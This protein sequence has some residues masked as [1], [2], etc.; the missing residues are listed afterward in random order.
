MRAGEIKRWLRSDP[1]VL[2]WRLLL[3]YAALAVC[4][5][6]FLIYNRAGI[7]PVDSSE[8][9]NLL[10]G[11]LVF[12][13]VSIIYAYAVFIIASLLPFR[14]RAN[15]WYRGAMFWYWITAAAVSTALNL[16]DAVYFRYAQKRFT[17]D[18]IFFADNDNTIRL[19]FKFLGENWYMAAVW[20]VLVAA[21]ALLYGRKIKPETPIRNPWVY[22]GVNLAVLAAAI[23]LCIGGVRGGFSRMTRPI[24]MSNATQYTPSPAKANL[25][26][27]NPFAVLRTAGRA[28]SLPY[29]EY[30]TP[31]EL[32]EIYTPY[33]YPEAKEFDFTP[34]I[35]IFVL[36]SFSAEHS[37]FLNPELYDGEPGYTPFL[38]S[39]MR[40]GYT[41]TNAHSS[42]H[43]SIE[44]LP[45]VM[46]SIPSFQ[47]PFVLMPQ[48][49]GRSR[50]LPQILTDKGYSTLFFNGSERGSMGF[51]AYMRSAGVQTVYSRV[52]FEAARGKKDFDGYWG[53]WDMPFIDW[54]GEVLGTVEQPFF[55]SVFTISSHHPFKVP[56]EY[57]SLPAGQTR[58]HRGIQ[59]TDLS[60]R[61]FFERFG[62]ED[63]FRNSV[64]VFVADHVSS[65]IYAPET[66]T[67]PGRSRI[68]QFIYTP[69][70]LLRGVDD[71]ISQQIDLMPTLMNFV[72]ADEP[73]F[74]FGRDLLGEPER[75][76]IVIEY[77]QGYI[78]QTDSVM[79]FFDG[80]RVTQAFGISDIHME[81]DINTPE[82]KEIGETERLLKAIIQQY[83][84]HIGRMDYT[85]PEVEE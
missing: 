81:H 74:A 75:K 19:I 1:A 27:S 80:E 62:S 33:H 46:G 4:R 44:A 82:N 43:K 23:V 26:L 13:T 24:A 21:L 8:V 2:A 17:A 79:V 31:Q 56:D 47:T 59:Y 42:G 18:E 68:I 60:I 69:Y 77:S 3:I 55:S 73:Y 40:S 11:S 5:L 70:G 49:L 54:M 65:E 53:I 36:E 66:N 12:D 28:G 76:P 29:R 9:W 84:E 6:V 48:A 83:Y 15:R 51:E 71:R 78:A 57:M 61:R 34:N 30:Y 50:Q 37:A 20:A 32:A 72:P 85:V 38:D 7:G 22:F 10:K 35:I 39:L 14:F 64:F 25:I 58:V 67:V 52:D 16:A 41:F 45:A 63:W